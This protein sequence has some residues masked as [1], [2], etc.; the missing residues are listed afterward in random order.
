MLQQNTNHILM[1]RPANFGFNEETAQ[2]NAFQTND[3]SISQ[4][5]ISQKAVQEFDDFVSKLRGAG[6]QVTVAEDSVHPIKPDAVFPNNWISLHPNGLIITY[7]MYA[8]T[9]RLER[10]IT[11][12]DTIKSNFTVREHID[13]TAYELD[14]LYLEGTGSMI[15]DRKHKLV[16]ACLSPRTDENILSQFCKYTDYEKVVFTSVDEK[17][18]DIYHTNVMMA[19]GE[20]FVVICMDSVKD[21]VENQKLRAIF[22]R[23]N[24]E[25]VEISMEQMNS[26]A[27]NMLQVCNAEGEG[28]LVMSSQAYHSL[29]SSQIEQLSKHTQILHSSLN[30]IETY[31]GGSARCMMAEVFLSP[32]K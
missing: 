22:E 4:S 26:F 2:N 31:G 23:T 21:K 6:V 18:Q 20:G 11:V 28:I 10:Q 13:M 3:T 24:K 17:G 14:N 30:T 15:F 27:G 9:R 16:Y 5:E 25:I 7:P 19:M 8:P 32:Q 1:V 29:N 12:M